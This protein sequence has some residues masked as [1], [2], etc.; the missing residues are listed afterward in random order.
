MTYYT[1]ASCDKHSTPVF[2]K[3]D[4]E[5]ILKRG[6]TSVKSVGR[7]LNKHHTLTHTR[8]LTL[9][10][11]PTS[12]YNVGRVLHAHQ[13]S[14]LT[15]GH[16]LEKSPTSAHNVGR[17]LHDHQTLK[18]TRGHTLQISTSALFAQ[19]HNKFKFYLSYT[20]TFKAFDRRPYPE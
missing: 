16:I 13:T 17:V 8:R 7:V 2:L 1:S 9:E 15:R 3:H 10:R 11:S 18:Y 6:L 14:A 19:S 12:V 5:T 20:F 4:R